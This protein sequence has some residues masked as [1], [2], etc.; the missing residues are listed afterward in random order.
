MSEHIISA[1]N[2]GPIAA[3]E[4]VMKEPGV[5]VLVAPNGSGKTILLD[6]VQAAARGEGKLPL[7]DRAKRGKVEAFG[8]TIT[9][10]GTC[11]HTGSFEVTNLEG[12]FDLA[13]LVDPRLK[14]PTAADRARIKALVAL[15]GVEAQVERFAEHEAF[16]DFDTV[17]TQ[18]ALATDDIIEMAQRI[19]DCYDAA[20]LTKE[21]LSEREYGHAAAL[22]APSDIDL[23][24]ECDAVVL[25][26]AYNAARDEVIR[27]Q[28]QARS[29]DKA[30]AQ[31]DQAKKL[32]EDIGGEGL[33]EERETLTEFLEGVDSKVERINHEITE[34]ARQ[35]ERKRAEL[36]DLQSK[37]VTARAR[38]ATINRQFAMVEEA[39]TALTNP[40]SIDS[41]D[42]RDIISAEE[43]MERC[44][45]AIRLGEKI[46]TAK[47]NM[48][49]MT[50]HRKKAKEA[51]DKA[52][53]YRDA[54]KSTD[55]VLSSCIDCPQLRV[56]S[57]GKNARLVTDTSRG[58]SI[59]FHELS[60]GERW[61]IA[62]DIGSDQVK[63]GGLLVISQVGWEGIDGA[64]R[65]AI[66]NHAKSRGVYILT[67]EAASDPNAE[68]KIIPKSMGGEQVQVAPDSPPVPEQ[69]KPGRSVRA[70]K[71]DKPAKP[72]ESF[73]GFI[74]VEPEAGDDPDE[75]P[76]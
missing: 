31:F 56:E 13:G 44:E 75:I 17:V 32:V 27:L 49:K 48:A 51:E 35:L 37:T 40:V 64:N 59:A 3:L 57:D 52:A 28:E 24:E 47:A 54:G 60:D 43:E 68:R 58:E 16:D 42:P 25:Q 30:R 72:A 36:K 20:A 76:F 74:G 29:A 46:R 55:E 9:I 39:R 71:A 14:S 21:R 69:P 22:V 23:T 70:P 66:H 4:F 2:L 1:E 7:R 73:S 50:D 26:S 8:A 45:Q 53:K 63:E 61:K 10:G 34:L 19:K 65:L 11:R 5:T 6:A 15:T 38:V 67:A 33:V 62:I 18:D 41:P 12:R